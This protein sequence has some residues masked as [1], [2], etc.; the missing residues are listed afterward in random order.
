MSLLHHV[1]MVTGLS[2]PHDILVPTAVAGGV[3]LSVRPSVRS[4]LLNLISQGHL[5][6]I[7]GQMSTWTQG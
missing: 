7:S 3:V 4:I 2:F 1:A 5:E 6:E